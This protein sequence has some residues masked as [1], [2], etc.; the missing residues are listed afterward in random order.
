VEPQPGWPEYL[1]AL[2]DY[3]RTVS[4]SLEQRE[5]FVVPSPDLRHP[6]GVVP[7][8][9]AESAAAL[10]AETERVAAQ[11]RT[12]I[13]DVVKSMRSIEARRRIEPC[14]AGGVVN[15]VF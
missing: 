5:A 6:A 8:E 12:W 7:P 1:D 9:H 11:V 2:E 15:S 14:K 3:L 4:G 10:L 13:D